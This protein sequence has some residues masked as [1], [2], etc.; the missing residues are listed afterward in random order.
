MSIKYNTMRIPGQD[1]STT[2]LV[3]MR[4]TYKQTFDATVVNSLDPATLLERSVDAFHHYLASALGISALHTR[5][6]QFRCRVLQCLDPRTKTDDLRQINDGFAQ[7][8]ADLDAV[9]APL[10]LTTTKAVG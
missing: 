10:D 1:G 4:Y 3:E 2:I 5:I 8:H 6:S 9:F 7:I